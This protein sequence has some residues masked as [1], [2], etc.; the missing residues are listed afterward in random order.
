M[1]GLNILRM[2]IPPSPSHPFGLNMVGHNFA[3]ICEGLVTDC[4]FP[5]LL[6]DL[7]VQQLPHLG[8]RSEFAVSP[9][10]VRILDALNAKP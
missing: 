9:C 10:V 4:T 3:A 2:V 7:S 1:H 8:R 6:H 5:V